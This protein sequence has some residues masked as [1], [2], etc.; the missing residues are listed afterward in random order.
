MFLVVHVRMNIYALRAL[1]L[2]KHEIN[3]SGKAASFARTG[4]EL[5]DNDAE[6]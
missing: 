6:L 4:R 3:R 1:K 2:N 5:E